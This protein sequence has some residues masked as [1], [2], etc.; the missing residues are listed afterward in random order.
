MEADTNDLSALSRNW[1]SSTFTA[2]REREIGSS[3]QAGVFME[4]SKC[5]ARS[6]C[7]NLGPRTGEGGEEGERSGRGSGS[8]EQEANGEA[9]LVAGMAAG[10]PE[11]GPGWQVR[12]W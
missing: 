3:C 9:P 12:L 4:A 10:S 2:S 5:S 1:E 7:S 6:T 8:G 11:V